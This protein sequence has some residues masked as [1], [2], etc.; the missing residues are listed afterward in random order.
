M[1]QEQPAVLVVLTVAATGS[2]DPVQ[3][4]DQEVCMFHSWAP[5]VLLAAA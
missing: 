3:L 5:G 4:C 1:T 2:H